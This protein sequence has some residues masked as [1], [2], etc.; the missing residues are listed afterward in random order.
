ME[1]EKGNGNGTAVIPASVQV[2]AAAR[3]PERAEPPLLARVRAENPDL[4]VEAHA[5][6]WKRE[7]I[8]SVMGRVLR[9]GV[10]YGDFNEITG[11]RGQGPQYL[12]LKPGADA[13]VSLF[14]WRPEYRVECESL[15]GSHKSFMV[16]CRLIS[17]EGIEMSAGLGSCNTQE[18]KHRNRA[19][20]DVY[21]T[22]LKMAKKRALVD[23]VLTGTSC[24]DL[25]GQDM[26]DEE[27][28][29]ARVA[30]ASPAPRAAR[31]GPAGGEAPRDGGNGK[32]FWEVARD[33][34]AAL[35]I[36][37]P[38][39][40][41]TFI[42]RQAEMKKW[43]P[44]ETAEYILRSPAKMREWYQNRRGAARGDAGAAETEEPPPQP[45]EGTEGPDPSVM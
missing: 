37:D 3:A 40:A 14:G 39:E 1:T 7:V 45:P 22:C 33:V 35:G 24:S 36:E 23:A 6:I 20:A 43:T 27:R 2:P 8:H 28:P 9:M 30:Q 26:E 17:G 11:K 44:M 31:T 10:H 4:P 13:I 42:V 21:N 38:R 15:S 16:E 32:R 18:G 19:P 34:A 41:E 29:S 25:F 12:L 5:L